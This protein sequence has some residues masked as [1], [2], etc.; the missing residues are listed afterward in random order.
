MVVETRAVVA[1]SGESGAGDCKGTQE[2][3]GKRRIEMFYVFIVVL[4]TWGLY[5]WKFIE[6]YV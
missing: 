3:L 2:N 4:V 1:W 6:L 5:F